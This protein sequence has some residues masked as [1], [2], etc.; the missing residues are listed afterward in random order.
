[1]LSK[2]KISYVQSLKQKKFRQKYNNFL[3]EGDK[4]CREL[5]QLSNTPIEIIFALEKW[6]EANAHLTQKVQDKVLVVKEIELKKI[7]QLTTPN[8]VLIIAQQFVNDWDIQAVQQGYNLYLDGIRDPGN[9]GTILRIADWFGLKYVFLSADCVD[10]YNSKVIQAS[11]GAFMRVKAP[12]I[13]LADLKNQVPSMPLLGTF[14]DG[15]DIFTLPKM[16]A[17]IIIIGNEGKGISKETEALIT[18]K[19]TIPAP[20][21]SG[22]ESLNAGVA[23]G[24]VVSQLVMSAKK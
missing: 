13:D 17:G 10:I 18:K 14:M 7:S 1:M 20:K 21:G 4:S 6:V 3:V 8:Q 19:I 5:L 23:T 24:I 15:E 16:E 2:A 9:M 12:I 22:A 11:M